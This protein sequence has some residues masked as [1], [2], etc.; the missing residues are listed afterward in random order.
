MLE[1]F[2]TGI[3]LLF[4]L[5]G[6]ISLAAILSTSLAFVA[7]FCLALV[8]ASYSY[9]DGSENTRERHSPW[10]QSIMACIF[11]PFSR[12]Y[13]SYS[14]HYRSTSNSPEDNKVLKK[15][16][17][18]YLS[19][20]TDD[21]AIFAASPHGLIA[22]ATAFL[23]ITPY[24][25]YWNQAVLCVHK[26]LFKIPFLRELFLALGL[27]NVTS[28]NMRHQL[29]DARRSICLVPG[30]SREMVL[31]K[32]NPI[33]SKH[34]GFL[35]LAFKENI[36]VI[37]I[38]HFGQEDVFPSY[39]T[40][41]LDK[42]R[43]VFLDWFGYPFPCW[44]FGPFPRKLTSVVLNP[45]DPTLYETDDA[46]IEKYYTTVKEMHSVISLELSPT[47]KKNDEIDQLT[48]I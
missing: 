10:V 6:L 19:T 31:N 7:G 39:S 28:E 30:G 35:I 45:I 13:L 8:Y 38:L 2:F 15:S 34:K 20:E 24:K 47:T 3:S 36:P 22:S 25:Q 26:H 12:H 41:W 18:N 40:P 46:F 17:K 48:S 9:T 1:L 21:V 43:L 44:F 27:V 33:Q 16:V 4:T 14:I 37:P 32:E 42:V 29:K 5:P 11:V 23:V